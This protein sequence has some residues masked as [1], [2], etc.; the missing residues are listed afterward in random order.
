MVGVSVLNGQVSTFKLALTGLLVGLLPKDAKD[1]MGHRVW[2]PFSFLPCG[3]VLR[4]TAGQYE[5]QLTLSLL[6]LL[7]G[8]EKISVSR[9]KPASTLK[10]KSWPCWIQWEIWGQDFTLYHF[11]MVCL[12]GIFFSLSLSPKCSVI[13]ESLDKFIFF[14]R[15]FE[16][17]ERG[18]SEWGI[19][20]E[21][22]GI[23]FFS[24]VAQWWSLSWVV[25]LLLGCI[26]ESCQEYLEHINR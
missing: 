15:A 13:R 25:L 17:G 19:V 5:G 24:W 18:I 14:P 8:K 26:S 1:S 6:Y 11:E 22:E 7:M 12:W 21:G 20:Q 4:C 9:I 16:S 2:T 10:M 3:S 23:D